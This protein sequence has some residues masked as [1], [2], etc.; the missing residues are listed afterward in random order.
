MRGK[1][2]NDALAILRFSPQ[3]AAQP[4]SKVVRSAQANAEHNHSMDAEDLFIK[5]IFIDEGPILKRFQAQC[6]RPG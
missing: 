6:P 3:G 4:I 2:V 1:G 5:T